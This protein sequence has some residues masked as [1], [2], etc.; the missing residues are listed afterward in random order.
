MY[1]IREQMTN[2]QLVRPIDHCICNVCEGLY[3]REYTFTA[4]SADSSP[5][6]NIRKQSN[7]RLLQRVCNASGQSLQ[8]QDICATAT[9]VVGYEYQ[10]ATSQWTKINMEGS[11]FI[12]Q[13]TMT[14]QSFTFY[15]L[16]L[17]NRTSSQN[18]ITDITPVMQ[19][20][21]E[22]PYM[23][24]R[25]GAKIHGFYFHN[26]DERSSFT[27]QFQK[28]MAIV[29]STP[30]SASSSLSTPP[31]AAI[32]TVAATTSSPQSATIA[33][34]TSS[35][36]NAT[37]DVMSVS[38]AAMSL[39]SVLGIGGNTSVPSHTSPTRTERPNA[40]TAESAVPAASPNPVVHNSGN[41]VVMDKHALQLTLL[42]LIQND[43]FI[44]ILH[45]QYL[46]VVRNRAA[47]QQQQQKASS[48]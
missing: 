5:H 8:I 20:Q 3:L 35:V 6:A 37:N 28:I 42:S 17:L 23:I 38:M 25:H 39:K 41:G 40:N 29:Q 14:G 22:S 43:Q 34:A 21:D 47:K 16:I 46:K 27:T 9:H 44:D 26:A 10:M 33:D 18:L 36:P 31:A 32:A 15:Q 12:V 24:V 4:M 45:S 13:G 1:V 30:Q 48:T 7:L 2:D 19:V 11:I